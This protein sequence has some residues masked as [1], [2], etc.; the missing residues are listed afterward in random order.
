M[1]TKMCFML[2]QNILDEVIVEF[3]YIKGMAFTQKQKNALSFHAS[4]EKIYPNK[5]ILEVSTKSQVDL[6]VKLSA[7]NLKLEG[8]SLECV[9]QSSKVFENGQ[10]Y[11]NVLELS[12]K[13]AKRFISE[14]DYNYV[15]E[16]RYKNMIIPNL[17]RSLFYD[18]IYCLAL[19]ERK[20]LHEALVCYEIFTDIEFN[21]KK[22]YNSQAR[23]CALFVYLYKNEK[24][25]YLDSVDLFKSLYKNN[26]IDTLV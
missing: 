15:V 12:P 20:E 24:L 3:T 17:P 8:Y 13:E 26:E 19:F 23:A 7:F 21:E 22:Q 16:F 11:K 9:F 2:T 10:Q 6:G 14:L 5:N 25:N 1:A 18:Y 4:I